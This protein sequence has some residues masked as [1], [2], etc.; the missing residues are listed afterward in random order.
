MSF[1][2]T[3]RKDKMEAL[4]NKDTVKNGV[5]SLLISAIALKEKEGHAELSND[6][7]MS[8][9]QKELKQTKE[10]LSLT[11]ADR[12]DLIEETKR[13][14]EILEAYLPKQ[15][16]ADELQAA[17]LEILEEKQL[18]RS[19]KSKG[20]LIKETLARYTG[21]TDGKAVNQ[22]LAQLLK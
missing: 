16:S 21:K 17:I 10:V 12:M 9:V 2:D 18:E 5:C 19:N 14:I 7:A 20:I 3:L 22:A 15:M 6:E 8:Y 1:L 11:P 13:K 4:K